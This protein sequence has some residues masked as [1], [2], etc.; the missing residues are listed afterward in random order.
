[1]LLQILWYIDITRFAIIDM[2][3]SWGSYGTF[4]DFVGGF[5]GT[6]AAIIAVYFSYQLNQKQFQ[7]FE[8]Q[9]KQAEKQSFENHFFQM[10]NMYNQKVSA[11]SIG[12]F[13]AE[14]VYECVKKRAEDL[15]NGM[16]SAENR[17]L[18]LIAFD[19]HIAEFG[20]EYSIL[21]LNFNSILGYIDKSKYSAKEKQFYVNI[22]YANITNHQMGLINRYNH[23]NRDSIL[24][25]LLI[26]YPNR[27]LS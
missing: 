1:M 18:Y 11:L 13:H 16:L 5:I 26:R 15:T 3:K 25:E 17:G 12:G 9:A 10:M 23:A 20:T 22:Y 2:F 19:E 6:I 4:G 8:E 7:Q 27:L 14:K 24:K 21:I